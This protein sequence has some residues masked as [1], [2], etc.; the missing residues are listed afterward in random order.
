MSY[1]IPKAHRVTR[2]KAEREVGKNEVEGT[3]DT[4]LKGETKAVFVNYKCTNFYKLMKKNCG[5]RRRGEGKRESR[6]ASACVGCMC[7]C[8]CVRARMYMSVCVSVCMCVRVRACSCACVRACVVC[9][10]GQC[11]LLAPS[12]RG[13]QMV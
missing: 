3:S 13:I 5:G 7:V 11:P 12:V 10:R 8:V 9:V 1:F 2:E 4:H 6:Q